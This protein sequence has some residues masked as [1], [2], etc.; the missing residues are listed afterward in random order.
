MVT[1][2]NPQQ[3]RLAEGS[4]LK[5]GQP[6]STYFGLPIYLTHKEP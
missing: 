5:A 4:P 3:Q 2:K 6:A 1:K